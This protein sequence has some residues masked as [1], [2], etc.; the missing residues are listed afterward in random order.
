MS[1]ILKLSNDLMIKD[2]MFMTFVTLLMVEAVFTG[3][4][5]MRTHR[6]G[7]LNSTRR[8]CTIRLQ[9]SNLQPT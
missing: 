3:L 4:M 9:K 5:W 6:I 2:T 7:P 8:D 1:S